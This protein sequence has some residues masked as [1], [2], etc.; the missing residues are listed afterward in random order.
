MID[1]LNVTLA[2]AQ[3]YPNAYI[4]VTGGGTSPADPTKTEGKKWRLV[5]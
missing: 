5:N 4:A 2:S 1:R 3:K